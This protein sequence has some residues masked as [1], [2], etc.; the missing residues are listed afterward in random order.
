MHTLALSRP[1][2]LHCRR[3]YSRSAGTVLEARLRAQ[4]KGAGIAPEGRG[5]AG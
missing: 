3:G 4:A 5:A 1:D 2:R